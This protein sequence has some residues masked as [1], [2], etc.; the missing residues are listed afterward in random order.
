MLLLVHIVDEAF[1]GVPEIGER[2]SAA[3]VVDED[4]VASRLGHKFR[5]IFGQSAH[6]LS[7]LRRVLECDG[8]RLDV[9]SE[10]LQMDR[11]VDLNGLSQHKGSEKISQRYEAGHHS[12]VGNTAEVIDG[13]QSAGGV[14]ETTRHNVSGVF[15]EVE[16]FGSKFPRR[17]R[18]LGPLLRLDRSGEEAFGRP[19]LQKFRQSRIQRTSQKRSMT[20]FARRHRQHVRRGESDQRLTRPLRRSTANPGII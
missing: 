20:F 7:N 6:A 11:R 1:A 5:V 19:R 16:I 9:G 18:S 12:E 2:V 3:P 17:G 14:E 10:L 13:T 4:P 15:L 8:V